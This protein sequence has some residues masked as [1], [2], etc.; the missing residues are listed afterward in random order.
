[1]LNSRGLDFDWC[2]NLYEDR[3]DFARVTQPYYD[4][5]YPE[6]WAVQEGLEEY[7]GHYY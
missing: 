2:V 4:T 3:D 1:M 6:W 7:A 5:A